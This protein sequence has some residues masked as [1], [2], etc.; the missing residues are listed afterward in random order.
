MNVFIFND[1]HSLLD[2]AFWTSHPFV[3]VKLETNDK[4]NEMNSDTPHSPHLQGLH[5]FECNRNTE[6]IRYIEQ[7]ES[8]IA[9]KLDF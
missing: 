1:K 9:G 8:Q 2:L 3:K 6:I 7:G 4:T 5:R